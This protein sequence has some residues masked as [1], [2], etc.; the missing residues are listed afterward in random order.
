MLGYPEDE[1]GE[2]PDAWWALTA[3]GVREAIAEQIRR[4]EAGEIETYELEIKLRHKNGQWLDVLSRGFPLFDADHRLVRLVGTHQDITDRKRHEAEMRLS[5]TVFANTH[6]GIAI[7][8]FVGRIQTV[9]PAFEDLLGYR[10]E[11]VVGR[12]VGVLKSGRHDAKFYQDFFHDIRTTD[13]WRGE[14]WNRC[15]DGSV[16]PFWA[17]VS[18]VRDAAGEPAGYVALYS[19]ISEF[20][21]SEA[22]L[23]FLVHHDADTAL[24][25]RLSLKNRLGATLVEMDEQGGGAALLHLELDRLR[26]IV[27]SL[28]HSVGD[29]LLVQSSQRFRTL[30]SAGD[31]LARIGGGEFAILLRRCADVGDAYTLAGKLVEAMDRPF[32]F[33]SGAKAYSGVNVGLVWFSRGAQDPDILLRQAESA[34]YAAKD[35]G[36]GVRQY[37]PWHMTEAHE[38]LDM[39]IGLR[40]ALERDEFVLQYQPLVDLADRRAFGVEALLRWRSPDGLIPPGQ[41]I[42]LAEKTG[43]IVQIGEWVLRRASERMK[44]WLDAGVELEVLSVNISPRQFERADVCDRIAAIIADTRLPFDKVEIEITESVLMSQKDAAAKLR[45]LRA[46]WPAR[47]RRRFRHRPFFARLSQELPDRQA[48]ARPRLHRRTCRSTSPAWRSPPRSSGSAIRSTSRCWRK[49]SKRRRR[50]SSWPAP[51]AG[52][53]RASCS[54]G[55]CGR[56]TFSSPSSL[57]R[58]RAALGLLQLDQRAAEVLGMQEQHRLAVRADPRFAV[59]EHPR[60]RRLQ[61]VARDLRMSATS[62]QR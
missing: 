41:F 27:E 43:L 50:R 53:L 19:D 59:A 52:S 35:F 31:M 54:G 22:R 24:P 25:N 33:A 44:A 26:T 47:R 40:R 28:G 11:E 36:G 6:E 57:R 29:E 15:K 38:R 12:F 49:A 46:A 7:T 39:E 48:E 32:V 16:R 2:Q 9:N 58:P 3:P 60:P 45:Q 23:G 1:I 13:R 21:R 8:D 51:A 17:T 56:R 30:L 18:V 62:K 42:P 55:R 37:E 4:L 34:L 61:G 5:S 14:I 20:K 10:A